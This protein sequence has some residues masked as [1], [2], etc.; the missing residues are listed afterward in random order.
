MTSDEPVAKPRIS[1]NVGTRLLHEDERVRV[2]LLDLAPGE[3]TDWHQHDCSYV[4]VV[5]GPGEARCEYLNGGIE[6]QDHDSAG[7]A[8]MRE[9][10]LPH[11]LVNVGHER[12][13]NVVIELKQTAGRQSEANSPQSL[14]QL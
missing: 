13:G 6:H 5:T 11:R 7:I 3:A 9:S 10:D 2:W 12:Y 1:S 4:F 14:E 8:E